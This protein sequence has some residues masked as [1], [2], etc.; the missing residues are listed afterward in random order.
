M[1]T[2][3]IILGILLLIAAAVAAFL[4]FKQR[5]QFRTL[6]GVVFAIIALII[7]SMSGSMSSSDSEMT[8]N[9]TRFDYICGFALG[10]YVR[11][12][13]PDKTVSALVRSDVSGKAADTQREIIK[14]FEAAW[15][16]QVQVNTLTVAPRFNTP[17]AQHR[18]ASNLQAWEKSLSAES[19]NTALTACATDIVLDFAQFPQKLEDLES[20]SS[21]TGGKP[22]LILPQGADQFS[23]YLE[24]PIKK[25]YVA[26]MVLP[27]VKAKKLSA[28]IPASEDEAFNQRF[29]M[30]TSKNFD[31]F[32]KDN[33]YKW[34]LLDPEKISQN[35]QKDDNGEE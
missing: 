10:K 22:M 9:L 11:E 30:V 23:Q 3:F 8:R 27:N 2:F 29:I 6:A 24:D 12:N 25:G 19:F 17:D 34:R 1:K 13:Y 28:K 21:L 4:G 26:A 5:N 32:A 15:G 35:E 16:S 31:D 20:L 18:I 14:G 7:F 33:S